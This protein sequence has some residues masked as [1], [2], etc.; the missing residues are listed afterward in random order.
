MLYQKGVSRGHVSLH[1]ANKGRHL[2]KVFPVFVLFF[3]VA[4]ERCDV[5]GIS[6][7]LPCAVALVFTQCPRGVFW[8]EEREQTVAVSTD[9]KV[10]VALSRISLLA[11]L[12]IYSLAGRPALMPRRG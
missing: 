2:E 7:R 9:V 10:Y 8:L 11:R 6:S 4:E 12:Y 5:R 3:L 1:T